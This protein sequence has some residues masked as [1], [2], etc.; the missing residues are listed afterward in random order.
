MSKR[1][2]QLKAKK[3]LCSSFAIGSFSLFVV[4]EYC[5]GMQ[6]RHSKGSEIDVSSILDEQNL[7]EL[8]WMPVPSIDGSNCDSWEDVCSEIKN[9][10]L[11]N[12]SNDWPPKS[13]VVRNQTLFNVKKS[14][15]NA[16]SAST[17]EDQLF[18]NV[19]RQKLQKRSRMYK[20]L[21]SGEPIFTQNSKAWSFNLEGLVDYTVPECITLTKLDGICSFG[22]WY[23]SAHIETG[24]DDSITFVPVE[25]KFMLIGK[26]GNASP[27][28]ENL[29]NSVKSV[30]HCLSKPPSS[31]MKRNVKFFI[32]DPNSLMVQPALCA[33]TVITWGGGPALVMGFEGKQENDITRK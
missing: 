24:G 8:G 10:C 25:K 23:T 5:L 6:T 18:V 22:N 20:E 9:K 29:I 16:V 13:I 19:N 21:Q 3:S 31:L 1:E 28:L 11:V 14:F 17:S 7:I 27:R 2:I 32:T 12:V 4:I 33:H 30:L 26:R 15:V